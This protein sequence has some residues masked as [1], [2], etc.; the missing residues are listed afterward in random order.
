MDYYGLAWRH[1]MDVSEKRKFKR[2]GAKFAVRRENVGTWGSENGW[3]ARAS[4]L[5]RVEWF[6]VA[7][8]RLLVRVR[9]PGG[10]HKLVCACFGAAR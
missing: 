6:R 9:S 7:R 5:V 2:L 8:I 1:S 10:T 3:V 4:L